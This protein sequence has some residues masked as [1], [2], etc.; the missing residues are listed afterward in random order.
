MFVMSSLIQLP[1]LD[2]ACLVHML[3]FQKCCFLFCFVFK[4]RRLVRWIEFVASKWRP[5][6]QR[7]VTFNDLFY[8]VRQKILLTPEIGISID[9]LHGKVRENP[10]RWTWCLRVGK[11][12]KCDIAKS[13]LPCLHTLI[14]DRLNFFFFKSRLFLLLLPYCAQLEHHEDWH[15][16]AC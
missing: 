4:R 12:C 3:L 9:A 15:F 1:F 6:R 8:F 7:F 10:R 14:I 11:F 2:T 16:Y 5:W 13:I